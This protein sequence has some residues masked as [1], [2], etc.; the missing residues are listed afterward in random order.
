M[1]HKNQTPNALSEL[2]AD[3]IES[4]GAA[5][6]NNWSYEFDRNRAYF[7]SENREFSIRD[8]GEAYFTIA[9]GYAHGL[10]TT[11]HYERSTALQFVV[12]L[13]K[14]IPRQTEQS[15]K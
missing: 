10:K 4:V 11:R 3:A 13:L 1:S 14:R 2:V 5:I 9:Y 6:A 8:G 12:K 15:S 7:K